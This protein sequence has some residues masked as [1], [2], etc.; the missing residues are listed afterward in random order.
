[1]T[2]ITQEL[3]RQYRNVF[4][5]AEGNAVLMDIL[6]RLYYADTLDEDFKRCRHNAAVDIL[7]C[8]GF[9]PSMLTAK[10]VLNDSVNWQKELYE[11]TA[12]E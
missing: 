11:R 10:S 2:P 12:D 4:G 8:C 9:E 7:A 1:M 3:V 6:Q 5:S